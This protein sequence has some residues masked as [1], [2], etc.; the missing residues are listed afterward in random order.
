MAQRK[1]DKKKFIEGIFNLD[2]LT[3][4][5]RAVKDDINLE[6][7]D[8]D[9]E[10]KLKYQTETNLKT[11]ED[12]YNDI[13]KANQEAQ[14]QSLKQKSEITEKIKNLSDK[15]KIL[16]EKV[17]SSVNISSEESTVKA[18]LDKA[19]ET[20]LAL[21]SKLGSIKG[22]QKSLM[23]DLKVI[24]EHGAVCPE[25]KRPFDKDDLDKL[26]EERKKLQDRLDQFKATEFKLY[27]LQDKADN[28]VHA[29]QKE[30]S[31]LRDLK[32]EQQHA[33][34]QLEHIRELIESYQKNLKTLDNVKVSEDNSVLLELIN[35]TKKE[36]DEKNG[37]IMSIKER[38]SKY[39]VAKFILSEEGVR[40]Y[41]IKKLL[42]LLNFR[43]KYYLTK[44]NSQYSLSFDEMFDDEIINKRG[45]IV[46][47]YSLSG[48]EAKM[49]DLACIW[50]FRDILKLQ[51]SVSYNVAFYDEILDSSMD[52]TN[53]EIVCSILNEIARQEH[54]A[55]YV[56]THKTEL[57][58]GVSGEVIRLQKQNGITRRS[59]G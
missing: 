50:A 46:S 39:E 19:K 9:V 8:L 59:D 31:K 11:Y 24:N 26:E 44:Q 13:I 1:P 10:E 28:I 2:V 22:E 25:C 43:I 35:S 20:Q 15:E 48:A 41:I 5:A 54:Q 23:K 49:L 51:G 7:R 53:S 57:M 21:S 36:R 16:K 30:L 34:D 17:E 32:Y 14:E 37:I 47:Y 42:D 6:K 45:L 3:K 55:T 52:S 58:K 29:K 18:A 33:K 40:A 4:M 56:I 27:E 38:L 12:R